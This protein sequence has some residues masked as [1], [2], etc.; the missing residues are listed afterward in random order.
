MTT[1]ECIERLTQIQKVMEDMPG[2]MI[3]QL[4]VDP[5][6]IEALMYAKEKLYVY[7]ALKGRLKN[8]EDDLK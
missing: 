4:F 1:Q 5:E 7:D 2:S 6:D 3:V 8:Q